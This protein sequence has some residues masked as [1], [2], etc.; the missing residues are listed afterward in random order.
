MG[1]VGENYGVELP[2]PIPVVGRSCQAGDISRVWLL[3]TTTTDEFD[4]SALPRCSETKTSLDV[5]DAYNIY[6]LNFP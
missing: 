4:F 1:A 6:I 2:S 5:Q 3:V